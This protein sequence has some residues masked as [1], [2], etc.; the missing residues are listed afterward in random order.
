MK[1]KVWLLLLTGILLFIPLKVYLHAGIPYTHDGENHL[2][3]FANYKLALKEG[4]FPPRFAPSLMNRYGYP[5]FNYNYPLP[6]I[7]SLPFTF[8]KLPYILTFKLLVTFSLMTGAIGIYFLGRKYQVSLMATLIGESLYLLNPYLISTILYR[9]S[10]GEVL[11]LALFPWLWWLI[12]T[13]KNSTS[14]LL[15]GA[16][17]GLWAAFFLAHNVGVLLGVPLLFLLAVASYGRDLRAWVRLLGVTLVGFLMS[18]W[19]WLPALAEKSLV[20]LDQ[21]G[22]SQ[23]ATFHFPTFSQLLFAPLQFGFSFRGSVDSLSFSLGILQWVSCLLLSLTWWKQRTTETKNRWLGVALMVMSWGLVFGQLS[24]SA[25]IWQQ[26]P[27]VRFIQ[28]P[29][30]L[31]LFWALLLAVWLMLSWVKFPRWAQLLIGL[32]VV[33]QALYFSRLS[34]VDYRYLTNVDYDAFS[35]STTTANE[36]LPQDF[37]YT[38]IG[39]WQPTAKIIEGQGKVVVTYWQG[40]ART[41]QL[42]LTES[43]L[44][45]EPTMLFAGWETQATT[46]NQTSFLTYEKSATI[47]GRLAYRLPAGEYQIAS[48]FTQRTPARLIGNTASLVTVVATLLWLGVDLFKKKRSQV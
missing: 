31:S 30:R 45:V 32:L 47:A 5:V 3:R 7:L 12:L 24:T 6:S 29:W 21:A 15:V 19:F 40:S 41:Y 1:N 9:G 10:I 37:T 14:S 17:A 33:A 20:V 23:T 38:E 11:I 16:G 22:L 34:A 18:L 13:L 2:A 42:Y 8:L 44:V 46:G 48:R 43:S 4:Q 28:F 25:L 35:Q 26:L 27:F 39:D 36:N